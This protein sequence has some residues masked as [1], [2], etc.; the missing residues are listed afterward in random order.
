M[1]LEQMIKAGWWGESPFADRLMIPYRAHGDNWYSG[2]GQFPLRECKPI[3]FVW[4]EPQ[5]P[6]DD[7]E[8]TPV[9]FS[10]YHPN[11]P[12]TTT[13]YNDNDGDVYQCV[14]LNRAAVANGL[15][16][17]LAPRFNDGGP[18][19]GAFSLNQ[20][21]HS[22]EVEGYTATISQTMTQA[23]H[24][25]CVDLAALFL[26]MYDLPRNP[27]R[28]GIGHGELSVDRTDGVWIAQKSGIPQEAVNKVLK[29]EKDIA[30]LKALA[31]Q[32]AQKDNAQDHIL[33]DHAL[34]LNGYQV[35]EKHPPG[36]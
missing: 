33:V 4:H 31:W 12:G 9:W 19:F 15:N 2:E 13:Y 27:R 10:R 5:E 3:A 28:V 32:G 30:E 11:Q 25:A 20:Q 23:Q 16:G 22:S 29:M 36:K 18:E 8:S 1:F 6:S 24:A 26:I 21:T 7:Y 35:H 17:K 34:R 14:P